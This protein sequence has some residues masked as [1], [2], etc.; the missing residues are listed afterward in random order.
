MKWPAPLQEARLIRRYKRFLADVECADGRILTLHCPNTGSMRACAEPGSRVWF[1]DSANPQRKYPCTWELVE[2]APG[3]LACINTLRANQLVAEALQQGLIPELAGTRQWQT[4]VR[5]GDE[6]SRIDFYS[7]ID[8]QAQYVEVKS[9]TL[10]EQGS[11]FF[12]DAVSARAAKHLRELMRVQASGAQAWVLYCVNHTGIHAVQAAQHIDPLY[13]Q[14]LAEA[15]QAGVRVLAWQ[16]DLT[17]QSLQLA[18]P[19]PVLA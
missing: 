7:Q 17:P 5:Y 3:E 1:W 12:P 8:Q 15:R 13:A 2:T 14:T 9:V 6:K 18:R 11:G 19:V 10:K 4:E 16:A